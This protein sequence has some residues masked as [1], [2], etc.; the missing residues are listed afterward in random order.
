MPRAK[1]SPFQHLSFSA[2]QLFSIY[3]KTPPR[4]EI[5]KN[6]GGENTTQLK[7]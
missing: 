1:P 6:F 4:S 5:R 7:W 2:F 3:P